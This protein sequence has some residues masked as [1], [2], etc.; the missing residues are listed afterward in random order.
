MADEVDAVEPTDDVATLEPV[1]IEPVEPEPQPEP[2]PVAAAEPEPKPEPKPEPPKMVPLR[3]L[4]E[5]IGEEGEKRRQAEELARQER[6]A[7]I[8]AEELVRRLQ[9]GEKPD[10]APPPRPAATESVAENERQA[11]INAALFE[12]DRDAIISAG[13]R[14][15]G[16]QWDE[17]VNALGTYG[18]ASP[19]FVSN[20]MDVDRERAHE[21]LFAISQDPTRAMALARMA[22]TR[23]IAEITRMAMAANTDPKP[24]DSALT[25]PAV[26]RAPTPKPTIAPRAPAP[27]VDP[28]TPEGNDKMSDAEFNE[29]YRKTYMKRAG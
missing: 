29:W 1:A 7:R 19:E 22:P 27:E 5:R 17:A 28:R 2:E 25:R 12:R 26:S 14:T 24:T 18:A 21:L 20:V 23:R 15:Y 13:V 11:I 4:Q 6:Q 8:N 9:A 16:A 10:T 3:V